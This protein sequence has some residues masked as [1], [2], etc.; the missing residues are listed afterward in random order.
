MLQ[1]V[2]IVALD[3]VLILRGALPAA[4]TQVLRSLQVKSYAWN[5]I[6]LRTQASDN[7]VG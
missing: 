1:F 7:L 3:R 4:D 2:Q 6:K 5:G